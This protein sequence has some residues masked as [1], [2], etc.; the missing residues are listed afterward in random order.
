MENLVPHFV[1]LIRRAATD[2]PADVEAAL[3]RARGQEEAGSAAQGTLDAI[4]EN[5][6]M[7]RE[8]STPIC[9]DTGT[10]IFYVYYPTG[11][12]T[13]TLKKQIRE[14]VAEA[15][16]KSYLRPNS[17]NSLTGRNTGN[18]LGEDFPYFHFEEWEEDYLKVELMLKGGGCENV[19]AQYSLPDTRMDADRDLEGVRRAV[20]D[21]VY[22][23]QGMGCAPAVIGVAIGGDRG[24][25]Y[26]KSKEQ[27]Y[28]PLEDAHP[29][30]KIA[31]LEQRLIEEANELGVGP[32]G[33]GGKTTVLSVKI[34]SLER[35][36]ACYFVSASYMCWADRRRTLIYRD[37]Q[38]T[39]E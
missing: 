7:S 29:D 10:P 16:A 6:Q 21:A 17:V 20:L 36:P 15:T 38:A 3:R 12:S 28:R 25:S 33:F 34:D 4:L 13:L 26:L 2:L 32:M 22:Q 1:E 18:N 39:I 11:W 14:A 30:P 31:A 24:T 27:F 19:G 23:A 35:L 9:Q 8:R 37:G 5:V